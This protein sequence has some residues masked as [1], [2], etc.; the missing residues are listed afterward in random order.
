MKK[1]NQ[2]KREGTIQSVWS[3]DGKL[4]VKTSASGTPTRTYCEE[5][6]KNLVSLR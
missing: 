6:L 2:M 4:F 1:A 5:D 3:L